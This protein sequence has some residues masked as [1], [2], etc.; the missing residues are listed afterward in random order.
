MRQTIT[1]VDDCL[2]VRKI[3]EVSLVGALAPVCLQ[4]A[5][6]F[7]VGEQGIE[8]ALLRPTNDQTAAKFRQHREIEASIG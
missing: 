3:L 5:L 1:V 2:T 8:E 4:S 6:C 7:E